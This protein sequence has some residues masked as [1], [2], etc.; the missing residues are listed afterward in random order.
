MM[1]V[2]A[3]MYRNTPKKPR[4]MICRFDGAANKHRTHMTSPNSKANARQPPSAVQERTDFTTIALVVL[5]AITLAVGVARSMS[6]AFHRQSGLPVQ[7]H[8]DR[9]RACDFALIAAKSL[10]TLTP[11]LLIAEAILGTDIAHATWTLEFALAAAVGLEAPT[12]SIDLTSP[13][14]TTWSK[15]ATVALDRARF[16]R[17]TSKTLAR[18]V[19]EASSEVRAR[20]RHAAFA[21]LLAEL[22]RIPFIATTIAIFHAY[23]MPCTNAFLRCVA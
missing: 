2:I 12:A 17:V 9:T 10:T 1:Q 14:V 13:M 4:R 20:I 21:F 23:P 16:A 18:A 3:I 19:W 6:R 15:R 8:L 11:S 22:A 7:Y 5:K